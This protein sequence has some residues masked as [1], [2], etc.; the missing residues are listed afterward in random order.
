VRSGSR[1]SGPRLATTRRAAPAVERAARRHVARLAQEAPHARDA[2]VVGHPRAPIRGRATVAGATRGRST[3]RA[4]RHFRH[5]D[6]RRARRLRDGRSVDPALRVHGGNLPTLWRWRATGE[7]TRPN[8]WTERLGPAGLD[9]GL[10]LRASARSRFGGFWAP[11][12]KSCPQGQLDLDGTPS[13][14]RLPTLGPASPQRRHRALPLADRRHIAGLARLGDPHR[15]AG[16][17]RPPDLPADRDSSPR[18]AGLSPKAQQGP[19]V[20]DRAASAGGALLA[21]RR[22]QGARAGCLRAGLRPTSR[23]V[24]SCAR[25]TTPTRTSSRTSPASGRSPRPRGAVRV[26]PARLARERHRWLAAL[27][28][29]SQTECLSRA[30]SRYL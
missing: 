20:P 23:R 9:H 5:C 21:S 10:K 16:G 6:E 1:T 28:R 26:P 2:L 27:R 7:G 15:G 12:L 29:P 3:R 4:L 30:K 22:V 24:R 17:P 19:T 13:P 11:R 14:E 8:A 25:A 18:A